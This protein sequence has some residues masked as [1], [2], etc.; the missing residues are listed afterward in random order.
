MFLENPMPVILCGIIAEAVLGIAL[1]RTGRGVLL[2]AMGGVL[3]LVLLGVGLEYLVVTEREQVET[4]LDEVAAAVGRN[5]R[6]GVLSHIHPSAA[7]TR[8]LV[9]WGF[10]LASF[11]DAKI[12]YLEVENIN[13]LTSPP[14]ARVRVKGIVFFKD[15]RGEDPYGKRPVNLTLELRRGSDRWLITSHQWHDDPIGR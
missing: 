3:A 13:H 2:W 7:E 5:D 12:T 1:L 15:R 6:S 8:Q 9:N 11:T 10:G 4:T 14:T